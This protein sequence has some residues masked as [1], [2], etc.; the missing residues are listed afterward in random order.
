MTRCCCCDGSTPPRTG[1]QRGSARRPGR[2]DLQRLLAGRR[3]PSLRPPRALRARAAAAG[4]DRAPPRARGR[5]D[6]EAVVDPAAVDHG[7][8]GHRGAR[9]GCARALG[10]CWRLAGA[11]RPPRSP[12]RHRSCG[13]HPRVRA[14]APCWAASPASPP[15]R[16]R[17]ASDLRRVSYERWSLANRINGRTVTVAVV[18]EQVQLS[19]KPDG[20]AVAR[21]RRRPRPTSRR[22]PTAGRGRQQGDQRR[23]AP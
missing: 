14:P 2:A 13:R 22:R 8:R 18:P 11:V 21:A 1:G 7:R 9:P 10:P 3:C 23:P 6:G 20:S 5:G 19:W 17:R 4:P 16:P 15:R 12:P